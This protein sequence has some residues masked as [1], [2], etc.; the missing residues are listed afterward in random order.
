MDA[1]PASIIPNAIADYV[2]NKLLGDA[3]QWGI[4]RCVECGLCEYVCPS[5]I[6]LLEIMRLGKVLLKG[7]ESLLARTNLKTLGW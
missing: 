3:E 7:E 1:C 4:F 2:D 6:P 5:R